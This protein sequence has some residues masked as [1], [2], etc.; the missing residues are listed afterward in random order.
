MVKSD[1]FIVDNADS[2]WKVKKYLLEWCEI[3]NKFDIATGFFEI[4]ALLNLEG[5][6]Q[7]LNEI[8]ILMGAVASR[9]TQQAF[10]QFLSKIAS[11][12]DQSIEK[13]K[14]KNDF[15]EGVPAIME[16]LEKGKIKCKIYKKKKFHAKALIRL[17]LLKSD[18]L[19][20]SIFK[21]KG[22]GDNILS[23]PKY[24]GKEERIYINLTQYFENVT[25]EIWEYRIGG[26]TVCNKWLKGYKG[27]ELKENEILHFENVIKSINETLKLTIEI[28]K[29]IEEYGGWP[30]N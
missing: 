3:A 25:K 11:K 14:E 9:R 15:L 5:K 16:S 26:Y 17:H 23:R 6:W 21:F 30:I 8:R 18:I 1:L 27:R 22:I 28:D 4:G 7:K 24:D 2:E 13:E 12:L 10:N 29:V 19:N 20:T